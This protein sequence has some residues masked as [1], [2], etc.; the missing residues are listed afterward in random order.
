MYMDGPAENVIT[1]L[2]IRLYC[3]FIKHFYT[4]AKISLC[5]N[6]P[7]STGPVYI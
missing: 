5:L 3:P 7:K 1:N 4:I 6:Q 2:I